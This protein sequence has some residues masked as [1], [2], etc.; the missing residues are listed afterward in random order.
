MKK[1]NTN[2]NKISRHKL[3]QLVT[4]VIISNKRD[5]TKIKKKLKQ[6]LKINNTQ[7]TLCTFEVGLFCQK[8]KLNF[9]IEN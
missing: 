2:N 5:K 3:S 7:Y 9:R 6:N 8:R 1:N 4:V